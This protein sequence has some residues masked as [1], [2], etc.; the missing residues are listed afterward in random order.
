MD[1]R[2]GETK[3]PRIRNL[4]KDP[5]VGPSLDLGNGLVENISLAMSHESHHIREM[6]NHYRIT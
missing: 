5:K 2:G 3:V 6:I 1:A 4:I